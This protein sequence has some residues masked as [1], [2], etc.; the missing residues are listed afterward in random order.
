MNKKLFFGLFITIIAAVFFSCNDNLD[1]EQLRQLELE[2]LA[3]Y[4]QVNYPDLEPTPSGLY[5]IEVVEG[6]GDTI[7][8][9]DR[10]QIFYSTWTIDS[11]WLDE[12][13]GYS[14]GLRYEPFEYIVGNGESIQG[15]DEASNFMRPGSKV[16]LVIPSELAYGQN[17]TYDVGGFTTLLM[18]IEVYKVYPAYVPEE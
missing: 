14:Q 11:V 12:T 15:L 9:G 5:Y 2:K 6:E 1:D 3:E 17:G 16:H 7:R 18:E 10:V 13:S 8:F 4:I